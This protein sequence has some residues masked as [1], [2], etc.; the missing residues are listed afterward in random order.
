MQVSRLEHGQACYTGIEV[1]K[2]DVSLLRE[3]RLEL[4]IWMPRL[5]HF[6]CVDSLQQMVSEGVIRDMA[7][8]KELTHCEPKLQ[9][10]CHSKWNVP[11]TPLQRP[12][13]S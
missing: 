9:N 8:A 1:R 6:D 10:Q 7:K 4:L 12:W 3:L 5:P 2:H 13:R 11:L